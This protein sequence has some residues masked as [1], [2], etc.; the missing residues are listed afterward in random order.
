M[1]GNSRKTGKEEYFTLPKVAQDC[2]DTLL[3]LY[4]DSKK[5]LEPSAGNGSFSNYLRTKGTVVES[6]ITKRIPTC[7]AQD[8][9]MMNP[10]A[11]YDAVVTNPPFGRAS[12]L[13]IKFFN[14]A[15]KFSDVI[16]FI[17]PSSWANRFF[18]HDKLD[19]SYHLAYSEEMPKISFVSPRGTV[20]E[21][22]Y[23][24]CVF[25]IWERRDLKRQKML[26]YRSDDFD[27]V[28]P[29][30][31]RE[32]LA[33]NA[34]NRDLNPEFSVDTSKLIT[35]RTHGSR[36]GE[37]LENYWQNP[38]TVQWILPKSYG[39]K[40]KLQQADFSDY[41]KSNAYIPSIAP[42]EIAWCYDISH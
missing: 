1:K 37:I 35:I 20:F 38:R 12:N 29:T 34:Y 11:K 2:V 40:E 24:N 27:F 16:A 18:I 4:P 32:I 42:A 17:V 3:R 39:V 31:V 7:I 10:I 33:K 36:A 22:E 26:N 8:F 23:L 13:A 9:L 6:D 5:F 15:T 21:G 30:N 28:K 41:L 19:L 25:Q 14:H